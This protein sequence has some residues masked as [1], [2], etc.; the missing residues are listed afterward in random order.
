MRADVPDLGSRDERCG[1]CRFFDADLCRRY[2]PTPAAFGAAWPA[3][4]E[5]DW[6]GEWHVRDDA[7]GADSLEDAAHGLGR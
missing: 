4:H 3:V 5:A 7:L 6:C 1:T 2:P